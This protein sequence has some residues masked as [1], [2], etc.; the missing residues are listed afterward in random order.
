MLN[1]K[2]SCDKC[3]KTF[4]SNTKLNNHMNK[5]HK[6][7]MRNDLQYQSLVLS[8]CSLSPKS[9]PSPLPPAQIILSASQPPL[10]LPALCLH[11]PCGFKCEY[12]SETFEVGYR[13]EEHMIVNHIDQESVPECYN[14]DEE[15]NDNSVI[16]RGYKILWTSKIVGKGGIIIASCEACHNS[17][18]EL[19]Q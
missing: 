15:F 19:C 16:F 11:I 12:C 4:V 10:Q 6:K 13:L 3:G 18:I 8:P 7:V 9:H 2:Y 5:C 17:E 14:C 1:L